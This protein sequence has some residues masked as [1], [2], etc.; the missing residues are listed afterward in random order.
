M[1]QIWANHLKYRHTF[2]GDGS[3]WDARF[4]DAAVEIIRRFRKKALVER[5]HPLVDA[6]YDAAYYGLTN[7]CGTLYELRGNPSGHFNTTSDNTLL[8]FIVSTL[9]LR[10]Q[11]L[12]GKALVSLQGDDILISTDQDLDIVRYCEDCGQLG[13]CMNFLQP[14]S[15]KELEFLGTHPVALDGTYTYRDPILDSLGFVTKGLTIDD[16]IASKVSVIMLFFHHALFPRL[17][18][19]C[20]AYCDKLGRKDHR[21]LKCLSDEFLTDLYA[22]RRDM[23]E[24][25]C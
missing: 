6:Y 16:R 22:G 2:S 12:Y 4:P 3:A 15:W 8:Q 11:N 25:L 21:L 5:A 13:V 9:C 1:K 18:E 19:E 7:V 17:R 10:R 20:R 23:P 14:K 24:E